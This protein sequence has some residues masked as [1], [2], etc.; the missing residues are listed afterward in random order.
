MSFGH[1][2]LLLTLLLLPIA[3][4]VYLVRRPPR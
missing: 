2:L 4:L 1:P 3:A